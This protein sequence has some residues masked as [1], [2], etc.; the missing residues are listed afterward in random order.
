[1]TDIEAAIVGGWCLGVITAICWERV[2]DI[3]TG[4]IHG[5]GRNG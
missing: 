1:M 4:W 3:I 2:A 5:G